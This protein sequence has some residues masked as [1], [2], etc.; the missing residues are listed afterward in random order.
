MGVGFVLCN[1]ELE[2]FSPLKKSGC[3]SL[4]Y[5]QRLREAVSPV[6]GARG[7]SQT[8]SLSKGSPGRRKRVLTLYARMPGRPMET[9]S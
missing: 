7:T 3:Y 5:V 9:E 8:L 6:Q 4:L 2:P 1:A